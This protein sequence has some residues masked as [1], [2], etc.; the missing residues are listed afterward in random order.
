LAERTLLYDGKIK[1]VFATDRED[2]AIQEFKDESVSLEGG[3]KS[4]VKNRAMMNNAISTAL[5][6]YLEG[7]NIPTHFIEKKSDK[8]MLVR[9]VDLI[10]V[11]VVVRNIAAGPFCER[12]KIEEGKILKYP[13]MEFFLKD[14]NLKESLVSESYVYAMEF[15][16]PE[17]MRHI[18]R[19]G[20]KIN[21]VLKDYFERRKVK[22][23]DFMIEFGRSQN[24][25]Y[26]ADEIVPDSG[27]FWDD[28]HGGEDVDKDKFR[29]DKGNVEE[30]YK[31]MYNRIIGE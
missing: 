19:L 30:S 6:E 11:D 7:Y 13:M 20:F 28:Q 24:Q 12:Y 3:K 10:P 4:K 17:E 29:L 22:L 16:T 23:V 2:Q 9:R 14:E 26:L 8:E 31:E 1:R 25:I 18:S 27:R 15:A 5:F 21:A